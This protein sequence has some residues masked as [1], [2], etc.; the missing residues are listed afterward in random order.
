MPIS[1]IN[2]MQ[3]CNFTANEKTAEANF[4]LSPYHLSVSIDRSKLMKFVPASLAVALAIIVF[5][6][7]GGPCNNTPRKKKDIQSNLIIRLTKGQLSCIG[8]P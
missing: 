1:S 2:M 6:H 7:P 5:P 8:L 4:W 3:G